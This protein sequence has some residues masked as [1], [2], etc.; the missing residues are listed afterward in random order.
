MKPNEQESNALGYTNAHAQPELELE[1]L[2]PP[3]PI[4]GWP[5]PLVTQSDIDTY[6]PA[7]Y[8]SGWSVGKVTD[9]KETS[10][11]SL[12]LAIKYIL[13]DTDLVP[14]LLSWIH[15]LEQEENVRIYTLVNGE[16]WLYFC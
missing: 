15:D 4:N 11:T 5:T 1:A 9:K 14:S 10:G 13:S 3:Q 8:S 16:C 2:A 7:L 6:F 12:A